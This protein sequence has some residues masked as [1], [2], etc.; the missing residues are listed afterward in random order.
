MVYCIM[1]IVRN[2]ICE[3]GAV[4]F[5]VV[6]FGVNLPGSAFYISIN[7]MFYLLNAIANF[8]DCQM[9]SIDSS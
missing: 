1:T 8:L 7:D 3:F 5:D 2:S 4:S 9:L 6:S